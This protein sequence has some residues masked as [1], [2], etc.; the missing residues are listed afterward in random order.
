MAKRERED[1]TIEELK[2]LLEQARDTCGLLNGSTV[3]P[4]E[5]QRVLAI[6]GV[7]V[8]SVDPEHT[9]AIHQQVGA[10]LESTFPKLSSESR[11]ALSKGNFAP[12]SREWHQEGVTKT[13][14]ALLSHQMPVPIPL[15]KHRHSTFTDPMLRTVHLKNALLAKAPFCVWGTVAVTNPNLHPSQWCGEPERMMCSEDGMK[16]AHG[17]TYTPT[18][19]HYDGQPKRVQIVFTTDTGPVRL[20]A[21][22]GSGSPRAQELISQILG[23]RMLGGFSTHKAAWDAHPELLELMHSFGVAVPDNGL[24]MWKAGVWH[25]EAEIAQGG[26]T[27]SPASVK[28]PFDLKEVE[29]KTKWTAPFRVYCGVV[30]LPNDRRDQLIRHAFFRERDWAMEPFA[31]VNRKTP[32]FVAEK[33]SQA[34][35]RGTYEDL[36]PEWNHLKATSF[37][38]MKTY[39]RTNCTPERLRLHGL[40]PEDLI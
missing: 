20:F 22:P 40:T 31:H 5:I 16:F 13:G 7:A 25:F 33:N 36:E 9:Q 11:Q 14:M 2:E 4:E 27:A 39:L 32:V 29:K 18:R 17:V 26:N 30:A 6:T 10:L 35:E 8:V 3:T 12:A 15:A 19:I 24:L 21:V 34:G 23:I 38:D 37:D 28:L 1:G